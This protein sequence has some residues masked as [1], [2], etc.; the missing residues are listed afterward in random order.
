MLVSRAGIRLRPVVLSRP[1]VRLFWARNTGTVE[2]VPGRDLLRRI[3]CDERR[4]AAL[5]SNFQD[6]P[7]FMERGFTSALSLGALL[8]VTARSAY[9]EEPGAAAPAP[10]ADSSSESAGPRRAPPLG[11]S[12]LAPPKPPALGGRAPSSGANKDPSEAAF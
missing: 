2:P 10:S 11:L 6:D 8:F 5:R 4:F 12:P 1:P 9:A 3:F 7:S